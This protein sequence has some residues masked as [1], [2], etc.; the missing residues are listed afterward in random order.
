MEYTVT[1]SQTETWTIKLKNSDWGIFR[2]NEGMGDF[3]FQS[4]YIDGNYMW[5][6]IGTKTL[7]E[8]V[9]GLD[10]SYFM[11]KILGSPSTFDE[12]RTYK[13]LYDQIYD[14]RDSI[15]FDNVEARLLWSI[16]N[17]V[18]K[19]GFSD[20][21]EFS[22]ELYD[23]VNYYIGQVELYDEKFIR[24]L[25]KR[26]GTTQPNGYSKYSRC[27]T[28]REKERVHEFFDCEN[29]SPMLKYSPSAHSF[30]DRVWPAFVETIK[31]ELEV[32]VPA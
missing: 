13:N 18:E 25:N 6:S 17:L 5:T 31:A 26:C 30:W 2:I 27:I 16:V 10:F 7:K 11:G 9:I 1:K 20:P 21:H 4:S 22:R 8:F 23:N 19:E 28:E 3:S 15:D 32:E 24:L 29:V 12:E 14:R